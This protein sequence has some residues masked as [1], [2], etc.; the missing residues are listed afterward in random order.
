MVAVTDQVKERLARADDYTIRTVPDDARRRPLGLMLVG[1]GLFF[2]INTLWNG[3]LIAQMQPM[4]G[5]IVAAL[6]G[7]FIN[8]LIAALIAY[9]ASRE[10]INMGMLVRYS[11]GSLGYLLPLLILA[12]IIVGFIALG[13]GIGAV[14]S[15]TLTPIDSG[16]FWMVVL[17]LLVLVS[18][19][20]GIAAILGVSRISVPLILLGVLTASVIAINEVG[21]V[22]AAFELGATGESVQPIGVA[23]SLV[24][25]QWITGILIYTADVYRFAPRGPAAALIAFG[26]V[27]I[28][29]PIFTVAGALLVQAYQIPSFADMPNAFALA[30]IGFI[31]WL[32]LVLAFWTTVDN[33]AYSSSQALGNAFLKN[34]LYFVPVAILLGFIAAYFGLATQYFVPFLGV[35]TALVPPIVGVIFADYFVVARRDYPLPGRILSP[36]LFRPPAGVRMPMVKY[37]AVLGWVA[38]FAWI[39]WGPSLIGIPALEAIIIAFAIHAIVGSFVR[40]DIEVGEDVPEAEPA[41]GPAAT[42]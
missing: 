37:G 41:P 24:V 7:A 16:L 30:G 10:G 9:L 4:P 11:F 18:S 1:I 23:I 25:A 34:R 39:V 15:T 42:T 6:V 2:V 20:I 35:I 26:A 3:G 13:L 29:Q 36:R 17:A 22:G 31:G 19:S 27:M 40:Q 12:F 38:G 32:T 14:F 5:V 21:G 8:A 33:S 28:G